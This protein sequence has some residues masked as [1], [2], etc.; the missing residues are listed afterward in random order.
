M[1]LYAD[2]KPLVWQLYAFD[3]A[4]LCIG[5]GDELSSNVDVII[6]LTVDLHMV[7][8]K[9][10]M[11]A[12]AGCYGD[13]VNVL[14]LWLAVVDMAVV[15]RVCNAASGAADVVHE[16]HA[17]ADAQRGY[18]VI[19]GVIGNRA[20]ERVPS[21]PALKDEPVAQGGHAQHIVQLVI[22]KGRYLAARR[23]G[24]AHVLRRHYQHRY[25]AGQN[26]GA[27]KVVPAANKGVASAAVARPSDYTDDGFFAAMRNFH[28]LPSVCAFYLFNCVQVGD[29]AFEGHYGDKVFYARIIAAEN[30]IKGTM[31]GEPHPG[32]VKQPIRLGAV[33]QQPLFALHPKSNP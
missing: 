11:Q 24:I 15:A 23:F 13:A 7:K 19:D 5:A 27:A 22:T 33:L 6:V 26:D 10:F 18:V 8:P 28:C 21:K 4:V 9:Y 32:I 29:M 20:V 12:G 31:A 16:L 2:H 1:P 3:N 30:G 14:L 25:S 17:H